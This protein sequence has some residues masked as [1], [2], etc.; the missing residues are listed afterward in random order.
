[1]P[2]SRAVTSETEPC[3]V[4]NH[5][6]S[7]STPVAIRVW[8]SLASVSAVE[9]EPEPIRR[10][11][12]PP[13]LDLS[14]LGRPRRKGGLSGDHLDADRR[15]SSMINRDRDPEGRVEPHDLG[16]DEHPGLRSDGDV[17]R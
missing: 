13:R 3:S 17:R 4:S 16:D 9:R 5:T 10:R 14:L 15:R 8:V 1:M 2:V 7:V 6:A 12:E 11:V